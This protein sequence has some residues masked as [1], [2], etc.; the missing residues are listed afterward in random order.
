MSSIHKQIQEEERKLIQS[1]A[2]E[3]AETNSNSNI[4]T[5]QQ[6]DNK[7][8]ILGNESKKEESRGAG[9]VVNG[10][11]AGVGGDNDRDGGGEEEKLHVVTTPGRVETGCDQSEL[12]DSFSLVDIDGQTVRSLQESA[13]ALIEDFTFTA[14]RCDGVTLDLIP[15]GS[16]RAVELGDIE[17]Y[18]NLYVEARLTECKP[19]I[20]KFR[21][22]LISIIPDAC[23][24]LL[25][26]EE[27]QNLV[28]GARTI[29]VDRLKSNTEYDDDLTAE[30]SHI[31]MFW[32][33]LS[34]MSEEMKSA[35]LRFVW[36]RPTLPP[37]G[38]DFN[39][40]M[41]ILSV[42][43]EDANLKP[44]QYLP[45]AHTCFFSINLPKYSTKSIMR[46]KLIYAITSCTEMDA[47]F[48][49]TETDIPGW[50]VNGTQ[51]I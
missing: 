9:V 15:N 35:F 25:S 51:G 28:C 10:V 33:I 38:V 43:G 48:R 13:K 2:D 39:Q 5:G 46:N 34:E 19:A 14:T 24:S 6:N 32:E 18:L 41:R 12:G 37:K 3:T 26:W 22:G 31:L 16:S 7:V 4:A 45:K 50:S 17:E 30:D 1:N 8:S 40:K 36:A 21:S 44:D 20:D 11:D 23:L 42:V 29:D 27:L 47:D 49:T